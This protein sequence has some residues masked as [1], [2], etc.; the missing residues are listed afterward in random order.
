MATKLN[1]I[2][3]IGRVTH[4]T[5]VVEPDSFDGEV[6][7]ERQPDRVM[8]GMGTDQRIIDRVVTSLQRVYD[9]LAPIHA[10]WSHRMLAARDACLEVTG[11]ALTQAIQARSIVGR[12]YQTSIMRQA[13]EM[14]QREGLYTDHEAGGNVLSIEGA[15]AQAA[16]GGDDYHGVC[17][18]LST[19]ESGLRHTIMTAMFETPNQI[20]QKLSVL[21]SGE[22]CWRD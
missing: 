9:A 21:R 4:S 1:R 14:C 8:W 15:I 12:E 18:I 22:M 13:I 10:D 5:A 7:T 16:L 6:Y 11:E 3:L 20:E 19:G 17:A 2:P